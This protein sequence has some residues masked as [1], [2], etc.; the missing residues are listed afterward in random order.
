MV[1]QRAKWCG[2]PSPHPVCAA[3]H[4][5]IKSP[6]DSSIGRV[7]PKSTVR[8]STLTYAF[9]YCPSSRTCSSLTPETVPVTSPV[10]SKKTGLL[11]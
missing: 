10:S 7:A 3:R 8:R 1:L 11:K 6:P 9:S 2:D 4:S 5:R